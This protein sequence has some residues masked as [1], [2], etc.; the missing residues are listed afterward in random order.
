MTITDD[1]EQP[2]R[3]TIY[4]PLAVRAEP[5]SQVSA[6][7]IR[8]LDVRF[9]DAVLWRY[10]ELKA[11]SGETS[12]G[13][14]YSGEGSYE[15]LGYLIVHATGAQSFAAIFEQLESATFLAGIIDEALDEIFPE[16]TKVREIAVG[17]PTTNEAAARRFHKQL[18]DEAGLRW[19]A[20]V[21]GNGRSPLPQTGEAKVSRPRW[22][23]LAI[24][25]AVLAVINVAGWFLQRPA[26]NDAIIEWARIQDANER[27]LREMIRDASLSA[28]SDCPPPSVVTHIHNPP[29]TPTTVDPSA[30]RIVQISRQ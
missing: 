3:K 16:G 27:E 5:N 4:T 2:F 1:G 6:R 15:Y 30:P 26:P 17:P 25:V 14:R 19:R 12:L 21:N 7:R 11:G 9:K 23:G 22:L 28:Q 10:R 13:K 24:A 8:K 29:S 20:P 18:A